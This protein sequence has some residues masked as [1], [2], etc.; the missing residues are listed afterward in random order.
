LDR[1]ILKFKGEMFG[2][3][4]RLLTRSG[5]ELAETS[6]PYSDLM[7]PPKT[8]CSICDVGG[9]ND[10]Q[11]YPTDELEL[12]D[13]GLLKLCHDGNEVIVCL[14]GI[15]STTPTLRMGYVSRALLMTSMGRKGEFTVE[16]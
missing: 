11:P 5:E 16:L 7:Q 15:L 8:D 13:Y 12:G 1:G 2:V 4:L 3:T 6:V 14:V 9:C 10:I